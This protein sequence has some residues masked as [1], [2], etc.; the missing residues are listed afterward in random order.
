M[1]SYF[2]SDV[3]SALWKARPALLLQGFEAGLSLLRLHPNL[4][5]V[6]DLAAA[7][8]K[9]AELNGRINGLAAG[10]GGACPLRW[11]WLR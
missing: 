2:S 4:M 6:T 10:Q 1:T 7:E 5:Q 3:Y 11:F 8:A 9:L